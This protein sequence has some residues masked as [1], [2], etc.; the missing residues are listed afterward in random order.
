MARAKE[1]L[2]CGG[3]MTVPEQTQMAFRL[4][5]DARELAAH[6]IADARGLTLART[7]STIDAYPAEFWL[8]CT[9]FSVEQ[10]RS[11]LSNYPLRLSLN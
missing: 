6:V 4:I 8:L 5:A 3:V 1:V 7:L 11:A 9:S 2:A 10:N